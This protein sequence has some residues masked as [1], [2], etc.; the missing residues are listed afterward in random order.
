MST[1]IL[2]AV[3]MGCSEN[4]KTSRTVIVRC[5]GVP[6]NN[7]TF[8]LFVNGSKVGSS[9]E[10]WPYSTFVVSLSSRDYVFGKVIARNGVGAAG[11]IQYSKKYVVGDAKEITIDTE[12]YR[13]S[14][15][16]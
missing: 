8:E 6:E 7:A 15:P 3:L 14:A 12:R 11:E 5:D 13:L 9:E 4:D 2:L 16:R 1:I 10:R